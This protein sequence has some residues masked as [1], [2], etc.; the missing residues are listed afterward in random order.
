M[1][2]FFMTPEFAR[3]QRELMEMMAKQIISL[4]SSK[5]WA[6]AN[7]AFELANRIVKFPT[8][9]SS[10]EDVKNRQKEIYKEF[11]TKFIRGD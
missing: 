3:Y 6:E 8:T 2:E 7:G 10:E 4:M 11:Q 5:D 9:I 1:R